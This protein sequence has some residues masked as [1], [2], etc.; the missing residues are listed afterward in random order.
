VLD[1]IQTHED[2]P[3]LDGLDEARREG[4]QAIVVTVPQLLTSKELRKPLIIICLAMASQQLSGGLLN[5][6]SY[7]TSNGVLVLRHQRRLITLSEC[8]TVLTRQVVLYYSNNIL[9][10]SLPGLGPYVS[11]GVTIVNVV[12]TFPPILL[13]EVSWAYFVL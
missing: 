10:K 6:Y 5:L 8:F 2:D 3:F 4:S 12:M 1:P 7:Q 11:L 9:S 13:V